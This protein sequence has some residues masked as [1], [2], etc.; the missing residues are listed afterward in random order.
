MHI[1]SFL[2]LKKEKERGKPKRSGVAEDNKDNEDRMRTP[3]GCFI[4]FVA[5]CKNSR[6]PSPHPP[7]WPSQLLHVRF[8]APS[9]SFTSLPSVKNTGSAPSRLSD[10]AASF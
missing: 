1:R 6:L 5:F 8:V 10:L 9:S 4:S 3:C 7:L 2:L